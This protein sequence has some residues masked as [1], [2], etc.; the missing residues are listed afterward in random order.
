MN[1]PAIGLLLAALCWPAAGLA[2]DP[3]SAEQVRRAAASFDEGSRAYRSEQF[4]LAASAFEAADQAVPTYKALRMAIRARRE[5][6]QAARASTLASLALER[7]PDDEK[8]VAFANWVIADNEAALH[9]VTIRC[10][11]AC[12]VAIGT[13]AVPGVPRER[14]TVWLDPGVVELGISFEGAG[15]ISE[16]V[17][18]T[19]GGRS[20]VK[21]E[22][23]E[24]T[25]APLP[26]PDP[27]PT[28]DLP[29]PEGPSGL[30]QLAERSA[31]HSPAVFFTG[32]LITAGLGG[33]TIWSGVD[34]VNNPGAD[35]VRVA[36]AGQGTDCPAYQDGR[37]KQLR[38]NVLIGATAGAAALTAVFGLFVTDWGAGDEQIGLAVDG[39]GSWLYGSFR[40]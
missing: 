16:S 31:V 38:T 9:R 23:P 30:D 40:F 1:R 13:R 11:T 7:H 25:V 24:P 33:T 34:T 14:I 21:L 12:V 17:T 26:A 36:C 35:A 6:G 4:E 39:D 28:P 27:Q 3:P 29:K 10:A 20:T 15:A 5:A 18:A 2:A 22:R 8:T 37:D 32:L 19:A